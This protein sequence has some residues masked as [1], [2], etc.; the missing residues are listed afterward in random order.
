MGH[1]AAEVDAVPDALDVE[2]LLMPSWVRMPWA[3]TVIRSL[4]SKA[5]MPAKTVSL[6]LASKGR[7]TKGCGSFHLLTM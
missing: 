1:P 7:V 6:M 5:L 4:I 3:T 2:V